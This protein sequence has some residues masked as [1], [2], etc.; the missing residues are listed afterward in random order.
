MLFSII[1][2]LDQNLA[3]IT[4]PGSKFGKK[5]SRETRNIALYKGDTVFLI[6]FRITRLT[7]FTTQKL[8]NYLVGS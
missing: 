1:T 4:H 6:L 5:K 3:K 7:M 8:V 2:L